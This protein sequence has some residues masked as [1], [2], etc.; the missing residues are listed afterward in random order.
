MPLL[1]MYSKL[2]PEKEVRI[3]IYLIEV[4]ANF[5]IILFFLKRTLWELLLDWVFRKEWLIKNTCI[6][7]EETEN[8]LV[9]R[10][11]SPIWSTLRAKFR[12]WKKEKNVELFSLISTICSL[13]MWLKDMKYKIMKVNYEEFDR[14]NFFTEFLKLK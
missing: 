7:S 10:L 2:K 8:W 6:W 1:R 4:I 5:I 11:K 14:V 9:N 13:V 12:K 3:F